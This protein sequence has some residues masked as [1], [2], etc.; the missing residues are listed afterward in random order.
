[1]SFLQDLFL[2]V[3]NMSITASYVAI[4]VILVRLL[5]KKAPKVFSYILWIPVLFRLVCPF[6]FDSAFSF[7]N[8]INLNAKQGIGISELVP[9]NIGLMH[10]PAIQSGIG[11]ID[12]E[13]N[14]SL[15]SAIPVASVNPM[16]IWM[17]VLSLI[18]ISGVIVLMIYG[19]IS[20]VKIKGKLQTATRV[21][22]DVFE[23]NA[24]GTAFVCG[25]IRPKIYVPANIG[26][27]NLSYILEHERT[28][29]RRKDYLIKPI[30]FLALILHWFNPLMW[31]CFALMS[32]DMEISCDESVLHRLGEGAKGG[33]SNS[34]LSLA[35]KRKGLLA[36][37]PLAFGES[38][39]KTRI[40]NIL[41]FKKPAFWVIMVA[42]VA[43]C[44]AAIAFA[45]N[46][47]K[48]GTISEEDKRKLADVVSEYYMK[49][50]PANKGTLKIY[51]IKK[52]GSSYLVLTQK[53]RGEGESFSVLFLAD[54][55]F[56]IVAKAPGDIPISPCFSANV[57]KYQGKS[58]VYGNFKNKK[59]NPQTDL[60]TDVQID[61]IKITFEDGTYVREQVSM[62]K[63]YI[64]VVDTLSNIRNIE[65]Y[66]SKGELQS[67]LINES[68]CSEYDFID[69]IGEKSSDRITSL[70]EDK[71]AEIMSSPK[72][73][74]DP[75][76]YINAHQAEYNAIL[77]LE[78]QALPYLFT[79]FE[80]GGQTGLK[81]YIMQNLCWD[82]LGEDNI[83][84]A[85]KDPQ[86]WYD[87][88]KKHVQR[89]AASSSV[90]SV[91]ANNPKYGA[92][93]D[94]INTHG[95]DAFHMG[96][97][98]V[99]E[100]LKGNSLWP[101]ED[102]NSAQKYKEGIKIEFDTD[103]KSDNKTIIIEPSQIIKASPDFIEQIK[104]IKEELLKPAASLFATVLDITPKDE[105]IKLDFSLCNI[106]GES[107]AF[108][109]SSSQ[110]FD[111]FITDNNGMEVYRWSH[112]KG[113][114]TAII[115]T[116][117]K[118]DEKLSFSEVWDYKDN[119]GNRVPPGKYTITVKIL[120]KLEN[121]KITNPDELTAAKDIEVE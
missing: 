56:N 8:L 38:H 72:N 103:V 21:E 42:V 67:D 24:I 94:V 61:F 20:Y 22:A 44:A 76:E 40:K 95:K 43:V 59:W 110:K 32:R 68:A 35:V 108:Y 5:L 26:D 48:G 90:D 30:A 121:T 2:T 97:E 53:Y 63:G 9:Q 55:G 65:V 10:T 99:E 49:A 81:G 115:N 104:Q 79:E 41:N 88:F 31:L 34:L 112:D 102:I 47:P 113:F 23:T 86:D 70:I 7:F 28:H 98:E 117:L 13:A 18:W 111:I 6:S 29:I 1:M 3:V 57:V 4:G 27:A 89:I 45:A 37:N 46:P 17:T 87:T 64:V 51:N 52:F 15:P 114:A 75:Q 92:L 69:V 106:S 85:S 83:Q 66:N 71:L 54:S 77:A 91:K 62:D 109:F 11:S 119:K 50:D 100:I 33:Y 96:F 120:A 78:T 36:A 73:S 107:L 116:K 80:K 101:S 12:S 118:K 19:I 105:A 14:A 25:F 39:V 74:S 58:I 16:E 60:V 82:I 84:Y 93:L